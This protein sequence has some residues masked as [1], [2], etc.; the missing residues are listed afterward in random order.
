MEADVDLAPVA[1]GGGKYTG[2]VRI[3]STVY[4]YTVHTKNKSRWQVKYS[5]GFGEERQGTCNINNGKS[6]DVS[7]VKEA[8]RAS[9]ERKRVAAAAAAVLPAA[10]APSPFRRKRPG[11]R[12]AAPT[13]N[14]DSDAYEFN[15]PDRAAR[16]ARTVRNKEVRDSVDSLEERVQELED[17]VEELQR[18]PMTVLELAHAILTQEQLD[19]LGPTLKKSVDSIGVKNATVADMGYDRRRHLGE[20]ASALVGRVLEMVK[21]GDDDP[22]GV[23]E[24]VTANKDFNKLVETHGDDVQQEEIP[25]VLRSIAEAYRIAR[26]TKD[27]RLAMSM[28]SLLA[29][30]LRDADI[31]DLCGD[32][33]ED[34]SVGAEVRVLRPGGKGRQ[35]RRAVIKGVQ[36]QR[37]TVQYFESDASVDK[38]RYATSGQFVEAVQS[39]LGR[40]VGELEHDVERR[41]MKLL[42]SVN[43]SR[44]A[45]WKARLHASSSFAG[46]PPQR[47][48]FT[49]TR[50]YGARAEVL[51]RA[52]RPGGGDVV[53]A[54]A[55]N[56]NL[57]AGV[58]YMRLD[59]MKPLWPRPASSQTSRPERP[60][61]RAPR[62]RP[63]TRP[64]PSPC[65]T[66]MNPFA[67]VG[68]R[69]A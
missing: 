7:D 64:S 44:D 33:D 27:T 48:E 26:K 60:R 57:T 58:S 67:G 61:A 55:S 24:L 38:G 11:E 10:D 6:V 59:K 13:H 19:K 52:L 36:D 20:V 37:Y 41:R 45:I 28:L 46:A 51:A 2:C 22:A 68:S 50:I 69:R 32:E 17:Q 31:I 29:P 65:S 5:P 30:H 16:T 56:R 54:A 66:P 25:E 3:G 53:H 23:F 43:V 42:G 39:D 1:A 15:R 4:K 49:R 12:R 47:A 14:V 18:A 21:A 34:I 35:Y 40:T 8:I 9:L 63:T 62:S